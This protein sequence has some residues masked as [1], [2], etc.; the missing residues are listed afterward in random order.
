MNNLLSAREKRQLALLEILVHHGK[1]T[2]SHASKIVGYTERTLSNDIK[3]I[4]NYITPS[5]IITKN[6]GLMLDIPVY[7]SS[8]EIYSNFLKYSREYQ[9]LL[10]LLD[11][12]PRSLEDLAD[13][14]YLSSSTVKRTILMLNSTFKKRDMQIN[15]SS[16]QLTGNELA[17]SS[18]YVALLNETNYANN[19]FLDKNQV[20]V[21]SDIY[22]IAAKKFD[23]KLNYPSL[24]RLVHWS[25]VRISRIRRGHLLF[26]ND[27]LAKKDIFPFEPDKSLRDK[28]SSMFKM[29]LDQRVLYELFFYFLH[30]GYAKN[31]EGMKKIT[32]SSARLQ[33]IYFKI[34]NT[35]QKIS[36]SLNISLENTDK[37][38]V[39][40]FNNIQIPAAPEFV[41]YNK[42]ELFNKS[43]QNEN[44]FIYN[45]VSSAVHECFP[46]LKSESHYNAIIYILL[47][48]WPNLIANAMK[49]TSEINIGFFF[50]SDTDYANFILSF[51]NIPA[52]IKVNTTIFNPTSWAEYDAVFEKADIVITNIP[53][54][55]STF[56]QIICI[57]EY[58][59]ENDREN[60]LAAIKS[61]H[62]MDLQSADI[63][64]EL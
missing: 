50:D 47:T 25:Y 32:K 34:E 24:I 60:I 39:D 7:S 52:E 20:S 31:F 11:G 1:C 15:L 18:F 36:K 46:K 51:L 10:Y 23:F 4:N 13:S 57:Q 8:R 17:I 59:T 42:N 29:D 63:V 41:I 3:Q 33:K 54:F 22:K 58:P 38:F 26:T 53:G 19:Y 5:K 2:L 37:L 40:L 9:M 21:L 49:K 43:F 48:H 27:K 55:S 12:S 64:G 30:G 35:L 44:E 6:N 62:K 45:A 16:F 28:F 14:L 56:S 61:H